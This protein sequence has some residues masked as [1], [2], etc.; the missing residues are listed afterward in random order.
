MYIR[1]QP[2]EVTQEAS[3]PGMRVWG[4]HSWSLSGDSFQVA[5]ILCSPQSHPLSVWEG[6]LLLIRLQGKVQKV[7]TNLT[8]EVYI[9]LLNY[10]RSG[11]LIDVKL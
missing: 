10:V 9:V 3:L 6:V 5:S 2:V 11:A 7:Y 8:N 1:G 4:E